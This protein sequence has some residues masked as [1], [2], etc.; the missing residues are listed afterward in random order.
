MKIGIRRR[1]R[2]AVMGLG[3]LAVAVT[4]IAVPAASAGGDKSNPVKI[5]SRVTLPLPQ[6]E[7]PFYGRVES[8]K[9]ACEVD[10]KVEVFRR[11]PVGRDHLVHPGGTDRSNRRGKWRAPQEVLPGGHY[12]ARV[13]RTEEGTAG[14]TFV[15]RGDRSPTRR[16][17][18]QG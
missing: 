8:S 4:A 2:I 11:Q 10:R 7:P 15:C 12:Y 6:K 5:D 3:V 16:V 14:K 18:H 9:H 1:S 13:V 17:N